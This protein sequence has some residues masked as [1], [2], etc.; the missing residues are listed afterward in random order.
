MSQSVINKTLKKKTEDIKNDFDVNIEDIREKAISSFNEMRK[1]AASNG[2][3]SD[4][5]I[6]AEIKAVRENN[7]ELES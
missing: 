3:M 7:R 1:M 5:E 6:E 2:Y 4:E